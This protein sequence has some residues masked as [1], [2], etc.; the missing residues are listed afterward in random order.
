MSNRNQFSPTF[1]EQL[2]CTKEFFAAF[3][4]LQFIFVIFWQEKIGE[5]AA[6][7]MLLKLTKGL[8]ITYY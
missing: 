6:R 1:Y 8:I 7:K 4:Q 2:F 3:L 5:K